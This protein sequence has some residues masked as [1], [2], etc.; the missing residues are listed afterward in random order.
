MTELEKKILDNVVPFEYIRKMAKSIE[1]M[2]TAAIENGDE[3]DAHMFGDWYYA[4]LSLMA[5]W[6]DD[7]N[8][9]LSEELQWTNDST[10]SEEG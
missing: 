3:E 10:I 9:Y 1:N 6:T 2:W 4:L 8:K 7:K 5:A